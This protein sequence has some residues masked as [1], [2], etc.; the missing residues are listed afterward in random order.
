MP[1]KKAKAKAAETEHKKF[2]E[3]QRQSRAYFKY[4]RNGRSVSGIRRSVFMKYRVPRP[5]R[6]GGIESKMDTTPPLESLVDR[7]TLAPIRAAANE[8]GDDLSKDSGK[9]I[10]T[11]ARR[12]GNTLRPYEIRLNKVIGWGGLGVAALF[13]IKEDR[14]Q[15]A[16]WKKVVVK[17]DL[18][19]PEDG[20]YYVEAEKEWHEV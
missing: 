6:W 15:Q 3:L 1:P 5:G 2:R 20:K 4:W 14:V 19:E 11:R 16:N 18:K 8:A 17:C 13:D 10:E 9:V 7:A 12:L